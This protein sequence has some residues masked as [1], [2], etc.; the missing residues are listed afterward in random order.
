MGKSHKKFYAY[1]NDWILAM[2]ICRTCKCEHCFQTAGYVS[3]YSCFLVIFLLFNWTVLPGLKM[4]GTLD[5]FCVY[6][7]KNPSKNSQPLAVCVCVFPLIYM[8]M[9]HRTSVSPR[10]CIF[11]H[12]FKTPTQLASNYVRFGWYSSEKGFLLRSVWIQPESSPL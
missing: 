3:S 12:A 4:R 11:T 2:K 1:W 7:Q 8:W 5:I 10:R 6:S 9:T